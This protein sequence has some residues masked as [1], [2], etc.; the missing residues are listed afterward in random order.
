LKPPLIFIFAEIL[1]L[2]ILTWRFEPLK[3]YKQTE[4]YLFWFFALCS[5]VL[6]FTVI[7]KQP[8]YLFPINLL[9]NLGANPVNNNLQ[10]SVNNKD[11]SD[12]NSCSRINQLFG[13]SDHEMPKIEQKQENSENKFRNENE[14]P[15]ENEEKQQISFGQ[16]L[17]SIS[18]NFEPDFKEDAGK[19]GLL[20]QHKNIRKIRDISLMAP[21]INKNNSPLP[22]FKQYRTDISYGEPMPQVSGVNSV[23]Q[24]MISKEEISANSLFNSS[25]NA[26][27]GITDEKHTEFDLPNMVKS[28]QLSCQLSNF[29]TSIP[30]SMR[31]TVDPV[32]ENPNKQQKKSNE[33]IEN[34]KVMIVPVIP[35]PGLN[36][37]DNASFNPEMSNDF[38]EEQE[39][40]KEDQKVQEI[41]NQA[42]EKVKNSIEKINL[43]EHG[44]T[45][46]NNFPQGDTNFKSGQNSAENIGQLEVPNNYCI[47]CKQVQPYRCKHCKVCDK[48]VTTFDH[49]CLWMGTC[50]GEKN[51]KIFYVYILSQFIHC[52]W[53]TV[54]ICRACNS[55]QNNIADWFLYNIWLILVGLISAYFTL[56]LTILFGFHTFLCLQNLTTCIFRNR[57]IL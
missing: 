26:N 11:Q 19:I 35:M 24:S 47:T 40:S 55:Y 18:F 5:I 6:Y 50:I 29:G 54:N 39:E 2:G 42:K 1:V 38:Q 28:H 56:F 46:N 10:N 25:C 21:N 34:V 41:I 14:N 16:N 12:L 22:K 49:H 23:E 48:C 9:N 53:T 51:K 3:N 17:N 13:N 8:G 44:S 27:I 20:T 32:C 30:A 31:S 15:N 7:F 52:V 43:D 57:L 36:E 45:G 4:F 37:S 33:N